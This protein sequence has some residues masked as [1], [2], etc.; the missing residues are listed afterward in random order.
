MDDL[1]RYGHATLSSRK[2]STAMAGALPQTPG[3]RHESRYPVPVIAAEADTRDSHFHNVIIMIVEN[4]IKLR[5]G[6]SNDDL[7]LICSW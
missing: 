1:Q 6:I 5:Q 2:S 3:C 7:H 4:L